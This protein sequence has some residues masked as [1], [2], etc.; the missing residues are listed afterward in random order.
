MTCGSGLKDRRAGICRYEVAVDVSQPLRIAT[1]TLWLKPDGGAA[2]ERELTDFP[3]PPEPPARIVTDP[4]QRVPTGWKMII[5]RGSQ[6]ERVTFRPE[7]SA[8]ETS[9]RPITLNLPADRP[10]LRHATR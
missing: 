7:T 1:E 8:P 4:A 6:P 2:S 5:S 10:A 9:A 3:D